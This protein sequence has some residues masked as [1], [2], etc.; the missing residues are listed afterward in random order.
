MSLKTVKNKIISIQ[1][2]GQVTKAMEAVSAV[3][4]R[5]SQ[6]L[7]LLGR[8]YALSALRILKSVSGSV[9]GASHPLVSPRDIVSRILIIAVTSDRG[10]AG[11]LNS[12]VLKE[13]MR[14]IEESRLPKDALGIVSV[15]RKSYDYFSKRKFTIV[16]RHEKWGDFVSLEAV[17]SLTQELMALYR[18]KECDEVSIVYTNFISTLRQEVRARKVLPITFEN[19]AEMIAG[20]VPERGKFSELQKESREKI[21]SYAFEPGPEEVLDTVIALLLKVEIYHSMLEANASEHS[22]RMIAM[23][24]ATDNAKAFVKSLRLLYNKERQAAI[25]REVSEIVSG[26]MA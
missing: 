14:K 23:K 21:A 6:A 24:N 10:L 9:D 22:A 3:K 5:K 1:K 26:S 19:I 15:G 12:A 13:C 4:M 7:A 25:T 16:G 2:T 11:S 8:P 18:A 20:I 17:E